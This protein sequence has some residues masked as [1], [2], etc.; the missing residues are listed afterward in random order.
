MSLSWLPSRSRSASSGSARANKRRFWVARRVAI[1]S[2]C[3]KAG[4]RGFMASSNSAISSAL[5]TSW[6]ALWRC[7]GRR[8][9]WYRSRTAP[10]VSWV[11][12]SLIILSCCCNGSGPTGKLWTSALSLSDACS[13]ASSNSKSLASWRARSTALGRYSGSQSACC[14]RA[15]NDVDG[16][17]CKR[18]KPH[19]ATVL[20]QLWIH[21]GG[22]T[23]STRSVDSLKWCLKWRGL[24]GTTSNDRCFLCSLTCAH[25]R[26]HAILVSSS[27]RSRAIIVQKRVT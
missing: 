11:M 23:G 16:T 5:L 10:F 22:G 25:R 2:V 9:S 15:Q 21:V 19:F 26:L 18:M 27:R 12:G 17:R 13:W 14:N 4:P 6:A 24:E 20:G 1:I 7:G 8:S 3:S